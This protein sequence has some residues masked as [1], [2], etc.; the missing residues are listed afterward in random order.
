MSFVGVVELAMVVH[1]FVRPAGASACAPPG[2]EFN[3]PL[4]RAVRRDTGGALREGKRTHDLHGDGSRSA[5]RPYRQE[6]RQQEAPEASSGKRTADFTTGGRAGRR[7]PSA[8]DQYQQ[9][10]QE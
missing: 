8:P 5:D 7:K 1:P 9:R 10:D 2:A 6:A 4:P 3:A